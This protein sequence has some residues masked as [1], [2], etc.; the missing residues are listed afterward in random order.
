MPL[1]KRSRKAHSRALPSQWNYQMSQK[2]H[3]GHFELRH[4][5]HATFEQLS[6]LGYDVQ[7][8]GRAAVP[9][10]LNNWTRHDVPDKWKRTQNA[11]VP[12]VA[13]LRNAALYHDGSALLPDDLYCFFDA[14][15]ALKNWRKIHSSRIF[16]FIDPKFDDALIRPPSRN[17]Y[18]PGRCFSALSSHSGN[19]GHFIHDLL[20][21]I[22][23][24]DL[25]AIAPSRDKIIAPSFRFPMQK[26]LFENIFAGYEVVE[27]PPDTSIEAEVLVYPANLCSGTM[28]N[29]AGIAALARRMRQMMVPYSSVENHKVCVSRRDGQ[30]TGGRGYVNSA[31]FESRMREFG[32]MILEASRL[33][34]ESQFALWANTID[35]VGVHGAG[36]MNMI[37]MPTEGVYTEITRARFATNDPIGPNWT[38][39]CAMAAGHHV[40]AIPGLLD[41]EGNSMIDIERVEIVLQKS[42]MNV[43]PRNWHSKLSIAFGTALRDAIR[44]SRN[45][46]VRLVRRKCG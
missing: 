28:F 24:E 15:F 39:R 5:R 19:F 1:P 9:L 42:G 23:Y 44:L 31:A 16:R 2:K 14:G 26:V 25:G 32:Y 18:V 30:T 37:M 21:R 17:M 43:R 36:M 34:P 20:S 10:E 40:N 8:F 12:A 46:I 27:I 38:A 11:V 7:W 33:S 4:V 45:S 29:S 22:Y 41:R 3:K 13:T 6:K 35:I